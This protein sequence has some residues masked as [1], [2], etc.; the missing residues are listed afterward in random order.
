MSRCYLD[1]FLRYRMVSHA[2]CRITPEYPLHRRL[3]SGRLVRICLCPDYSLTGCAFGATMKVESLSPFHGS[4]RLGRSRRQAGCDTK[5]Q[6]VHQNH[7]QRQHPEPHGSWHNMP[8]WL[9]IDTLP[10]CFLSPPIPLLQ[11]KSQQASTDSSQGQTT[12]TMRVKISSLYFSA[13]SEKT[14]LESSL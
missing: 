10:R 11:S 12:G 8:D 14:L 1:D 9:Q 2:Q 5:T 7:A 3:S 4:H 13:I 6:Q